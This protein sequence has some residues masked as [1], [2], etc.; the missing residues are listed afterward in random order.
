MHGQ[1]ALGSCYENG[2]GVTR[3]L[4]EAKKWYHLAAE[5]GLMEAQCKL[6]GYYDMGVGVRQN[7]E[8]AWRWRQEAAEQG[9]PESQRSLAASDIRS[10]QTGNITSKN[11]SLPSAF[12]WLRL[13]AENSR[14]K[15]AEIELN[16]LRSSM[17]PRQIA[18]GE[19]RFRK[20]VESRF[21]R[22]QKFPSEP[23]KR[24]DRPSRMDSPRIV[25]MDD[26]EGPRV[27][28]RMI[29]NM[30]FPNAEVL[31]FSDAEA[32]LEELERED[33]DLFTTDNRHVKVSG[34]EMVRKLAA[35]QVKYP[36][37]MIT[38]FET[39]E[40]KNQLEELVNQGLNVAYLAKPFLVEDL[41]RLVSTHLGLISTASAD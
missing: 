6:A 24:S 21:L 27:A 28:L 29:F 40:L 9:D 33:P 39:V 18:D 23:P 17:E 20:E 34:V 3:N 19:K 12:K 4:K 14:D 26:E 7:A 37:F 36:I 38:A 1:Y 30:D 16:T 31:T 22:L 32:A 35:K 25:V 2:R 15:L 13:A 41:R 8:E 11:W 5:R 10:A